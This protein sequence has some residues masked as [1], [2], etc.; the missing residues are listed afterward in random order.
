[1]TMNEIEQ[2]IDKLVAAGY[3]QVSRKY[4]RLARPT[5]EE[6][7]VYFS[8]DFVELSQEEFSVYQKKIG[9]TGWVPTGEQCPDCLTL[10]HNH[11]KDCSYRK[12]KYE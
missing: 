1:M 11:R 5:E 7:N 3:V 6:K 4:R 2:K 10:G 8:K 9:N 12:R